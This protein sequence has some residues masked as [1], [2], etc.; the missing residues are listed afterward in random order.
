MTVRAVMAIERRRAVTVI[1]TARA[2]T[3]DHTARR[4]VRACVRVHA[5][6]IAG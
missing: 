4:H 1:V 2:V 3:I 6:T 5:R